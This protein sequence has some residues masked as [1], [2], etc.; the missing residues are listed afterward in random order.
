LRRTI[1]GT[2]GHI[3]HGKTAL[4]RALTGIDADRLPEEKARGITI[5]LGF[6]HLEQGETRIG[7]V[8]APGHERFVRNMLAGAGGLDALLLVVAA[9]EGIKPQTREHFAIAGMLGLRSGVVA[10]TKIDRVEPEIAEVVESE[11]REFLGGSFLEGS[12]I[13]RV[14]ARTG[15]GIPELREALLSLAKAEGQRRESRPLRLPV[16]RAFPVAGFGPVVTGSL[17]SGGVSPEDRVE[18]LPGGKLARVRRVEVHGAEVGRAV[19]G[20][21][22]SLNLAGVEREELVRGQMLVAPGSILATRRLLVS[23]RLLSGA[24]KLASGGRVVLYHFASE[25]GARVRLIGASELREGEESPALLALERPV[26]A[27]VGDRF[28]LRRPSPPATIGGGEI[29]DCHP[30]RRLAAEDLAAFGGG[31]PSARLAR[32]VDR[33]PAGIFLEHLARE[34]SLPP[35]E[36][37]RSLSEWLARGEI[38]AAG[39]PALYLSGARLRDLARESR[40]AVEEEVRRRPGA[41][42]LPRATLLEKVFSKFDPRAAEPLLKMAAREGHLEER[43][44]EIRIAGSSG[45]SEAD[46]S[47]AA[48]IARRFEEGRLDPPSP[49]AV[50]TEL[51]AKPKIVEGLVGFLLKERRLVRLPGGMIVSARAVDEVVER[52]RASG[53]K[54]FSVPEFKEMFALT[55]RMAIPLLEHLDEA[56]VTRRSGEVRELLEPEGSRKSSSAR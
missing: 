30:P 32:R 31:D 28:I 44:E 6:A 23:L 36:I 46:R 11:V 48:R 54:K 27:A 14:S 3:D 7:F 10:L 17:I 55:R 49:A 35:E 52:L 39:P 15:E 21:R 34:E 40:A 41:L 1:V 43:G 9:D 29:L 26:A 38:V 25:T 4:L 33:E 51:A 19:A 50:A 12:P 5:D 45:L 22:T 37:A 20:E 8:D 13:L 42:G 18:I 24:P 56:R 2:A 53:K 16:D 47:L